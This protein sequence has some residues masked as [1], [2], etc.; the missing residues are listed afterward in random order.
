[1]LPFFNYG[2]HTNEEYYSKNGSGEN[3]RFEEV[4]SY[5][6]PITDGTLNYLENRNLEI[7][8]LDDNVNLGG[9]N[10]GG[11]AVGDE[12]ELEDL[13]GTAYV[14]LRNIAKG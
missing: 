8:L 14:P 2:F 3:P 12:T 1:M 13:I 9:I 7:N 4:N 6:L 5:T 11:Q 10:Q